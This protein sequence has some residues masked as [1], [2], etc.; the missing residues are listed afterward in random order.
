V[1]CFDCSCSFLLFRI[2]L[3]LL[4]HCHFPWQ[5]QFNRIRKDNH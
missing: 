4:D 2:R 3:N 5:L 1:I